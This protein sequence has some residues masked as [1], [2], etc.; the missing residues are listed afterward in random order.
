VELEELLE[1]ELLE[2]ELLDELLLDDE[3]DE[4]LLELEL[5]ELPTSSPGFPPQAANRMAAKDKVAPVSLFINTPLI[6]LSDIISAK[7]K[8]YLG[9]YTPNTGA[10]LG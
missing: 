8:S 6:V 4:E 1:E 5:D 3:L 9:S 7:H 10:L 2:E